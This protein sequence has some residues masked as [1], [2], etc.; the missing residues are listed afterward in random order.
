MSTFPYIK[1]TP[2]GKAFFGIDPATKSWKR[3]QSRTEAEAW[4]KVPCIADED[5]NYTVHSSQIVALASAILESSLVRGE[6]FSNPQS[7]REFARMQLGALEHEVFGALFLDNRHRLIAFEKLFTGT[8]DGASVYPR[9]V[10]KRTLHHNA[11]A[12]I[13][14]HNHP[15]GDTEPSAADQS[16]TRRLKAALALIDV[17]V[18]DH[19][20]VSATATTSLSE[21]GLI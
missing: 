20:V 6:L 13:L 17:R 9:E 8:I 2:D 15:S 10:V 14:A 1:H 4:L 7:A 12:L 19:I 21:R 5:G 3:F 11:G 18:L 16:I